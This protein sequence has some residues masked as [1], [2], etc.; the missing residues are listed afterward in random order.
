MQARG[1]KTAGILV[2]DT[3][4]WF[5]R[6]A[7]AGVAPELGSLGWSWKAVE[8]KGH[9]DIDYHRY[10][11]AVSDDA[12]LSGL[13]YGHLKLSLPQLARFRQRGLNIVGLT[14]RFDG[15]D[16]ITV[17]EV[18]G[19]YLATKHL[20]DL[21]HRHLALVNGP[22]TL[23]QC[24]LREDGFKRA[25]QARGLKPGR[26]LDIRVL[27]LGLD[28]GREAANMLLDLSVRP[29]AIF[30]AAGD[31]T[32]LGVMEGLRDRGLRVPHDISVIGFD[33]LEVARLTD[34]PLTT[35][36]QPLEA[37]GRWAARK[38]VAA[39][40]EGADHKPQGEIYAAELIQRAT[41]APL[42]A[43]KVKAEAA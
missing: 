20:L 42:L 37:M 7:M 25:M 40:A 18:Q 3:D 14:E 17:D 27:N 38:L 41:C 30:V 12:S 22:P 31:I 26:E 6:R 15:I 32:A 10:I 23:I 34:P 28:E 2:S 4:A 19:A 24:A 21:G 29:T 9:S 43:A 16:W 5:V 35:V 39:V 8:L 33:D 1:G 13:I 11:E 36:H